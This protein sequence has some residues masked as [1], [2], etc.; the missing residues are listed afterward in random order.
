MLSLLPRAEMPAW[1]G[2]K[3]RSSEAMFATMITLVGNTGGLP[4]SSTLNAKTPTSLLSSTFALTEFNDA[5]SPISTFRVYGQ[6]C[7]TSPQSPKP[8]PPT[9]RM[10]AADDPSPGV[11]INEFPE[12]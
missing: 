11:P 9:T 1:Y 12:T 7:G 6:G 3:Q 8:G 2:L 10:P 5:A 4:S